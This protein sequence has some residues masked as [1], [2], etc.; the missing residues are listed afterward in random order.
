[1]GARKWVA[2]CLR[3]VVWRLASSAARVIRVIEG[4]VMQP[5]ASGR[6]ARACDEPPPARKW[7]ARAS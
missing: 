7:E 4:P 6:P 2:G 3:A 1:M 5:R